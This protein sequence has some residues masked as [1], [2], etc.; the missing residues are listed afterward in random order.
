MRSNTKPNRI[1]SATRAAAVIAGML[2]GAGCQ[3]ARVDQPLTQTVAGNDADT[4]LRFWHEL[5]YRPV[6]SND[7]GFHGL[8]LFADGKD[9]AKSYDE[10]VTLLKSR[11][12]LP[13]SFTGSADAALDHGTLAVALVH[14]L[15]I[16]GGLTLSIFKTSPR[17]ATRSLQY[18]GIYATSTPNQGV[19]GPEFTGII[20]KA[21]DFQRGD[22][23]RAPAALLPSEVGKVDV[24]G[25]ALDDQGRPDAARPRPNLAHVRTAWELGDR[26][27]DQLAMSDRTLP[28][29]FASLVS[30]ANEAL[31]SGALL[32][33]LAPEAMPPTTAPATGSAV[34][35]MKVIITG[36][37]G[38][39]AEVRKSDADAWQPAKVGMV[40]GPDAEFRTGP[41]SAIRFIIPP[42]QTFTLD[43]M[44]TTKVLQA[45]SGDGKVK[46]DVGMPYGRVR[47]DLETIKPNAAGAVDPAQFQVEE[48][49]VEYDSAIRSPNS[50]LAVR[51]TEVSLYDQWPFIPQ[52]VSLT[53]RAEFQNAKKQ[54]IAFGNRGQGYTRIQSNQNGAVESSLSESFIDPTITLAR[55]GPEAAL[56][57]S[58]ISRGAVVS[59]DRNTGI[60]IIRGGVPPTDKELIPVLPGR[61]NFVLR[62]TGNANLDLSLVNQA[63]KSGEFMLPGAGLNWTRSGGYSPFDHRG[64]PHGGIE[65]AYWKGTFPDGYYG[66]AINYVSGAPTSATIEAFR[67]GKLIELFD[68]AANGG[69]GGVTRQFVTKVG[70]GPG[71]TGAV[72]APIN[73][74]VPIPIISGAP[75]TRVGKATAAKSR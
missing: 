74:P 47:Y 7:E 29:G 64:G 58:L 20:G 46:T 43:R 51:G 62:W 15:D 17:Y 67:D 61:L 42:K 25:V 52:A 63:G 24:N 22:S 44:G 39:L 70:P 68:P 3:S 73:V 10:R 9:T 69:A 30:D 50:T 5:A 28:P 16:R 21:E 49:G 53:G 18:H 56:V 12:M 6:T 26:L 60:E 19:S 55:T 71:K 11:G 1:L 48:A 57:S 8:L 33:S 37:E 4:Q 14:I 23:A 2:I 54:T 35:P 59:V 72:I 65:L 41:K 75:G 13:S 38:E 36:V 32:L 45:I 31:P 66:L 27:Q 40:V 34:K